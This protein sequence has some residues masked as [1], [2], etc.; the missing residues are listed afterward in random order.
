MLGL[1]ENLNQFLLLVL[2]NA[3]VGAMV[4]MER[5]ILPA[6]A[7]NEFGLVARTAILSF[8]A[9]FGVT[10]AVSNY[11][12]GQW[13]DAF[14]RRPILVAGWIVAAPVPFMLMWRPTHMP[15]CRCSTKRSTLLSG[16]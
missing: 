10:K 7:E 6:I 15:P 9:V 14:G 16:V 4:G 8:I 5:S 12:A 11:F 2:I 13:S 1:R 3:F